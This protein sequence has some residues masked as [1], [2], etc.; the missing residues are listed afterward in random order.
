MMEA[1]LERIQDGFF[2]LIAV[3]VAA[4]LYHIAKTLEK[5]QEYLGRFILRYDP[6][7]RADWD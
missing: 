5:I 1:L 7:D 4:F 2:Y 6:P 3:W